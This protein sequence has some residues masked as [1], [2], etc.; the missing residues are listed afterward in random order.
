MGVHGTVATEEA[1]QGPRHHLLTLSSLPLHRTSWRPGA[2]AS[3]R[4]T[5]FQE[6]PVALRRGNGTAQARGGVLLGALSWAQRGVLRADLG[7]LSN[8]PERS[9]QP[10][11]AMVF[12]GLQ[13]WKSEGLLGRVGLIKYN[14][15]L[16]PSLLKRTSPDLLKALNLPAIFISLITVSGSLLFAIMGAF[17][18]PFT[19]LCK[20]SKNPR[21]PEGSGGGEKEGK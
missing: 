5:P 21:D 6:E 2:K 16:F 11:G 4:K 18:N 12:H 17:Y 8:H 3:T 20:V 19:S 9:F 15:F 10:S 1:G 14:P 13:A 7:C